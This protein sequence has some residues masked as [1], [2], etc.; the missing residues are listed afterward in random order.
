MRAAKWA[1]MILIFILFSL[2]LVAPVYAGTI[3]VDTLTDG[4]GVTGC[5]LREA[6]AQANAGVDGDGC[7]G[8]TASPNTINLSVT[9]SYTLTTGSALS[10][11]STIIIQESNGAEAVIE[12]ATTSNTAAYRVFSVSG[13]T[14]RLTLNGVTVRNGGNLSTSLAGG[15]INAS[16]GADVTLTGGTVVED[17]RTNDSG[18]AIYLISGG[19]SAV[20]TNSTVRN[21]TVNTA[22]GGV[23]I[24]SGDLSVSGSTF[25]GNSAG[26]LGGAITYSGANLTV[27]SS[28][29]SNNQASSTGV[30]NAAGGA[31]FAQITSGT[32]TISGS[33]FSGNS[34]SGSN[35]INWGGAIYKTG[36]GGLNI[37]GSVF[38]GNSVSGTGAAGGGVYANDGALTVTNTRLQSNNSSGTTDGDAVYAFSGATV[39]VTGSCIVNNGDNAVV[40]TD[41]TITTT[42]TGNW[43]GTSWGPRILGAPNDSGSYVS[44]GDSITGDGASAVNVGLTDDGDYNTAPLGNWLTSVPS[45]AGATCMSCVN[46][47]SI[48]HTA[49][50]CS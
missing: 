23:Y 12:A 47:S 21:N 27:S 15:C 36:S 30:N 46:V 34:V 49:R 45:V 33:T 18:G 13:V 48:D 40:D 10:V 14:T 25:S 35:A 29:F 8:V 17:C 42:A 7:T 41:G 38:S 2:S 32:R 28:T 11:T 26:T 4:I 37:S 16:G 39:S 50:T 24:A 9:G 20:I 31:I 43:W 1:S 22:G 5:S 6:I 44:N 3:T 19:G